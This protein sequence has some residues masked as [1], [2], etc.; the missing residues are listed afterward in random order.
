MTGCGCY[1]M[2]AEAG[3]RRTLRIA[4][5]LNATMF[6]IGI[7]AGII[8]Q[9]S[10][11]IADGLDMLADAVAYSIALLATARSGLFKA[12]AATVSGTILLIL[13]IGVLADAGR[14]AVFGSEPEGIV[15]MAV[16]TL[17]LG[18]NSTVLLLLTQMRSKEVH[19]RATTIFT[20]ADVIANLGVILSGIVVLLTDFRYVDLIAGCAIGL[21]VAKE[22]LEIL[23]EAREAR[24]E[25]VTI[26][27]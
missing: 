22:A 7:T 20:R 2:E 11:L 24:K 13:G 4:L 9:S 8:A 27:P 6:V 19:L 15:M 14:R 25:D 16:A 17:S 12:R 3:Q 23:G 26:S 10:G 5:G 21:Y 1:S 18:V